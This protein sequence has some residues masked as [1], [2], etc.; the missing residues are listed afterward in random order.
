M[1]SCTSKLRLEL[2]VLKPTF[3]STIKGWNVFFKG[4]LS[5][6]AFCQ[7][8]NCTDNLMCTILSRSFVG[9]EY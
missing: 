6:L 4:L 8:L 5:K 9:V 7:V 3:I 2:V 1:L